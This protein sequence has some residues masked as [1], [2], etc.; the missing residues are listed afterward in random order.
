VLSSEVSSLETG[1]PLQVNIGTLP[2]GMY[3]VRL[4]T[5]SGSIA[6]RFLK[7]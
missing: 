4:T 3:S 2:A 5:D 1:A 7:R 6:Q